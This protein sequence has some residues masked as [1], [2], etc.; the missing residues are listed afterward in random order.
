MREQGWATFTVSQDLSLVT[1]YPMKFLGPF[2]PIAELML[3]DVYS[4]RETSVMISLY[5]F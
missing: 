1:L 2:T 5:R 3:F 4:G